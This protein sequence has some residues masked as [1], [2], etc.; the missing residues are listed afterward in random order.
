MLA[1]VAF[2][3]KLQAQAR[4]GNQD[5]MSVFEVR[6]EALN[7]YDLA[8]SNTIYICVYYISLHMVYDVS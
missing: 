5:L 6:A 7:T 2:A 8:P 1:Y 4:K 3:K